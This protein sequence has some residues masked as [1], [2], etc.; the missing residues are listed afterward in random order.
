MILFEEGE[1]DEDIQSDE[2]A[3]WSLLDE[4]TYKIDIN[5]TSPPKEV[6]GVKVL[7]R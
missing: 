4:G 2:Q 1:D 3:K 6:T 7:W 5:A